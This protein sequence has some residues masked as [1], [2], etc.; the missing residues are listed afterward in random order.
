MLLGIVSTALLVLNAMFI[1]SKDNGSML[2]WIMLSTVVTLDIFA[3]L[4]NLCK[5]FMSAPA[6]C[7]VLVLNRVLI[8]VGG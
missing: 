2:G 4:S 7:G 6:V 3:Y 1:Q 8:V 5:L